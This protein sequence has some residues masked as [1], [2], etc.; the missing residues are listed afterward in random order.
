MTTKEAVA[1]AALELRV[2]G[3]AAQILGSLAE[4]AIDG[5]KGVGKTREEILEI[6]KR[7]PKSYSGIMLTATAVVMMLVDVE[8]EIK[9]KERRAME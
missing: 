9:E 5:R 2:V 4:D 3:A 7:I 1:K 8:R 6:L